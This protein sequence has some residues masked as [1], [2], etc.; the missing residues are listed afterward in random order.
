MLAP[1]GE[2]DRLTDR[3][4]PACRKFRLPER[5]L[6][7][8]VCTL[9]LFAL[10]NRIISVLQLAG[11]QGRLLPCAICAVKGRQFLNQNASRPAIEDDVMRGQ[12][13]KVQVT[14]NANQLGTEERAAL[15]IDGFRSFLTSS[16]RWLFPRRLLAAKHRAREAKTTTGR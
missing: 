15:E 12:Q 2:D 8:E 6:S 9:E 13:Q 10:P 1:L 5:E 11:G 7:L 3:A 16:A 14:M 4:W